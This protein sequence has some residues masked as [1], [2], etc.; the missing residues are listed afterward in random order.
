[1]R[2]IAEGIPDMQ[3]AVVPRDERFRSTMA[4]MCRGSRELARTTTAPEDVFVP[5][6]PG[7]F[8]LFIREPHRGTFAGYSHGADAGLTAAGHASW[9]LG[10]AKK[11]CSTMSRTLAASKFRMSDNGVVGKP[12]DVPEKASPHHVARLAR[13]AV[14]LVSRRVHDRRGPRLPRA[15]S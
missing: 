10:V 15:T 5:R 12:P 14:C 11:H 7:P 13:R 9:A 4:G 8:P 6:A 1:M 2:W 3:V